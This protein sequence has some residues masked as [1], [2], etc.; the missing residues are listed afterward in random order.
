MTHRLLQTRMLLLGW[1]ALCLLGCEGVGQRT[2]EPERPASPAAPDP[3]RPAL[4]A[5]VNGQDVPIAPLN[6]A[7]LSDYGLSI[8]QQF[9][10]DEVVRQEL[11]RQGMS[12][13]VTEMEIE[14]ETARALGR[15]FRFLETPSRSQLENLLEQFLRKN[16]FTRRQW[17]ATMRRNA[18]LARLAG[19]KVEVTN[20]QLRQAYYRI[21]GAKRIVRHIQVESMAKAQKVLDE[22]EAGKDFATLAEAYSASPTGK[23]GGLLPPISMKDPPKRIPPALLQVAMSMDK[24]GE[25]SNPVQVGTAFH[26]VKYDALVPPENVTFKEV[27][28]KLVPVV[29]DQLIGQMQQRILADLIRQADIEYVNPIIRA[30]QKNASQP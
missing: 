2:I 21:Y 6:D 14:A 12:T 24:P 30:K 27:R 23:E 19:P 11:L 18:Q 15:I 28:D 20:E 3:A 5:R 13:E 10:A 4:L 22:L 1:T 8:A 29:R 7:L 17:D 26:V 16:S 9:I 25:I